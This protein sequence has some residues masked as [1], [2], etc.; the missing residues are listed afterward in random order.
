MK[1]FLG[2]GK[3]KKMTENK[4][5]KKIKNWILKHRV[6]TLIIVALL[7]I[8]FFLILNNC[9]IDCL[10]SLLN[11]ESECLKSQ[12]IQ[13]NL[14]TTLSMLLLTLPTIFI[15][16][17]FRTHDTEELI[18]NGKE[19]IAKAELQVQNGKEQITKAERQIQNGKEQNLQSEFFN[20]LDGLT[21]SD[22]LKIEIAVQKLLKISNDTL[23]NY[24]QELQDKYNEDIKF[25]F[26]KRLK[27]CPLSEEQKNSNKIRLTYAQY[28]LE[29]LFD[30]YKDEICDDKIEKMIENHQNKVDVKG[31]K[32]YLTDIKFNSQNIE[33]LDK[34]DN[35]NLF[36]A[37]LENVRF[38]YITF[39]NVYLNGA[40][41]S[42]S[43]LINAKFNN[44]NLNQANLSGAELNNA[45]LS[46]A[47]LSGA[48]LN[49]ALYSKKTQFPNN[50]NPIDHNMI[51]TEEK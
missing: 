16:W 28:I 27:Q 47:N 22:P 13:A 51:M 7:G 38:R 4:K 34:I 49:G 40:N 24:S 3:D 19:Q 25:A 48:K 32:I 46:G 44:V 41:L 23:P 35:V 11:L 43:Q 30:R 26:V 17:F 45:N 36:N 5:G 39:K 50:F 29:W 9:V 20:A 6:C 15:I 2:F 14:Q 12:R 8:V 37:D 31:E 33:V 1:G 42:R 21:N 18:E 10:W